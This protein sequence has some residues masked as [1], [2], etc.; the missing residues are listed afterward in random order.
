[1]SGTTLKLA[2]LVL[3]LLDHIYEFI[4]GMPI[5]FTWLGRISAPMFMFC[6]A[7]GLYYTHD[8]KKYLLNMYWWGIGMSVGDILLSA[9]ILGGNI[10]NN[11]IFTTLFLIGV[12]VTIIEGFHNGN[13]KQAKKLLLLLFGAQ[14]LSIVAV[15]IIMKLFPNNYNVYLLPSS[16]FGGLLFC[17]GGFIFVAFGVGLY[18][19]KRRKVSFII[20]YCF[21]SFIW[22]L[23]METHFTYEN[24]FLE[25]YQ[26]MMVGALPLILCYNGKKGRGLKWL[27]YI[28][29]PAHIFL[30]YTIGALCVG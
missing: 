20:W 17:E 11:N 14:F 13:R 30:L 1:M 24:L 19:L 5:W 2:A 23:L 29:Y 15:P 7:W 27:F 6:M 25:N 26:W 28:F 4:D 3:M 16:L 22:L 8:R 21:F 9:L 18:F 12:I 10:L